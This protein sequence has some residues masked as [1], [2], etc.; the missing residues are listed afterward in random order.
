MPDTK[1]HNPQHE[2][3]A[4]EAAAAAMLDATLAADTTE[5]TPEAPAPMVDDAHSPERSPAS[6]DALS[7]R[8]RDAR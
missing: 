7:R 2:A 5:A 1:D 4:L 8:R 3:D 6:D